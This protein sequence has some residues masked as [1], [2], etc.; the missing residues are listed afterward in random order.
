[1]RRTV[2]VEDGAADVVELEVALEARPRLDSAG[3][4]DRLDRGQVLA[5]VGELAEER[6]AAAVAEQVVVVVE[7]ERPSPRTGLSRDE[8]DEPGLDEVV[9]AVVE[10][11]GRGR[12]RGARERRGGTWVGHGLGTSSAGWS[13]GTGCG[14]P[15]RS[16]GGDDRCRVPRTRVVGLVSARAARVATMVV[17]MSAAVTP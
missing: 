9:E 12:R 3:R 8:P 11:A 10:R 1:M 17:S 6:V 5:L 16:G 7:A 4:V 2:G 14:S 15:A 13:V